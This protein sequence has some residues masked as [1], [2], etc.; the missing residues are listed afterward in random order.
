MGT[1]HWHSKAA[2]ELFAKLETTATRYDFFDLLRRIE[3]ANP[4]APRLGRA[5]SPADEPLRVSQPPSTAF[6]PNS[7][8]EIRGGSV[9]VPRIAINLFGLLGPNGP[10]P[11]H[12]T[13]LVGEGADRTRA[14]QSFI[15]MFDHRLALFF[16]RAW[17]DA[18]AVVARDRKSSD[19]MDDFGRLLATLSGRSGAEF[20]A[21]DSMDDDAKMHFS[22]HLAAVARRPAA[23]VSVLRTLLD[24]GI[25]LEDLH[26]RWLELPTH[27]RT[28]LGQL[29]QMAEL[30]VSAVL[31]GRVCDAQS[32]FRLIAG[33]MSL[34]RYRQF[35]PGGSALRL[36]SDI[37][38]N[39]A[40]D[41]FDCELTVTLLGE[42]VPRLQLGNRDARLG[43]L[44]WLGKSRS[45]GDAKD[46]VLGQ[47]ALEAASKIS[48]G[49]RPS[50]SRPVT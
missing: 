20:V 5:S 39:V 23:I 48:T 31:G 34:D 41:E 45:G 38:R 37:L 1:A 26:P 35:L 19:G 50:I 28:R 42:Q 4:D 7:V 18:H 9:G 21:Q 10:M 6:A 40:G 22:G 12:I 44:S 14:L 2:L 15:E 30:G 29:R 17:A 33:P 24:V 16:Y 11:E 43:W 32:S 27:Q 13:E 47:R 36:A 49:K 25:E 8:A 46:L 3:C